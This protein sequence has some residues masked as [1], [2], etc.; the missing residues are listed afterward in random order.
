MKTANRTRLHKRLTKSELQVMDEH[1][2]SMLMDIDY[3]KDIQ[4]PEKIARQCYDVAYQM[5][6]AR[7]R[8]IETTELEDQ[9]NT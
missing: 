4:S 7:R 1:A 6:L 5:I 3:E 8:I 9:F 2:G